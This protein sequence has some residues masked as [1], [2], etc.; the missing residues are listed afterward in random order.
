MHPTCASAYVGFCHRM[1][2]VGPSTT[3]ASEG[4]SDG[5]GWEHEKVAA[6]SAEAEV[7]S[8]DEIR[9]TRTSFDEDDAIA[10]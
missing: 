1:R 8:V 6:A 9:T 4:T 2:T 5:E 7:D 3:T 10:A